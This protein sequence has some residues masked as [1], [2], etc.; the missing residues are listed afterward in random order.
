M[1]TLQETLRGVFYAPFYAA[2]AR[3]VF[4]ENDVEI[5]FV[6]SPTPARVLDALMDG[7]VD[8]GW[9]GPMRVNYGNRTIPGADIVGFAEVVTRDPFFLIVRDDKG[10]YAPGSI[11][12]L[13]LGVTSEVP[14]PWLCLQHD[15]RLA[16]HDPDAIHRVTG[17]TMAEN[18]SAL[19]SG[20]IDVAQVFQPYVEYLIE[21]GCHIWSA[22]AQRGPC[23][24][25]TLYARRSLIARKR[26]ELVR[27]VR[28]IAQTQSWLHGVNGAELAD[29]VA[30]FFPGL[31]RTRLVS[32]LDRYYA[33]G[34]WGK[35]PIPPRGGYERLRDSLVSGGLIESGLS[36]EEAVDNSL[37][38][39]VLRERGA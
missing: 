6:S 31:P 29:T 14:T 5:R 28:A 10:P 39:D 34:I 3:N 9:G 2:L 17:R 24:Y 32:A 15:V 33:L 1:I 36:F 22:A 7:S 11:A 16:G 13:R 26:P 35:N 38:D 30:D 20:D 18:S 21:Q 19:L 27:M 12:G 4:A 37:A 8:V 25:T 23:S